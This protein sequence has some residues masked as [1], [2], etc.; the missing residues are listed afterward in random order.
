MVNCSNKYQYLLELLQL[1]CTDTAKLKV[2]ISLPK[3]SQSTSSGTNNYV[4]QY[5]IEVKSDSRSGSNPD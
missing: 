3:H 4:Q 5:T 1:E 2:L